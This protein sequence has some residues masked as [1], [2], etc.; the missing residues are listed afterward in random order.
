MHDGV[1][2]KVWAAAPPWRPAK[3]SQRLASSDEGEMALLRYRITVAGRI[4]MFFGCQ[5]VGMA[6]YLSSS[7]R[8][9]GRTRA[10]IYL[11]LYFNK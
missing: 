6:L 5:Q 11:I 2:K 3:R 10:F 9:G 1:G 4:R 7:Y 8:A